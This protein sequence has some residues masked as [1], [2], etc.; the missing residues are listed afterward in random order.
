MWPKSLKSCFW[1]FEGF[2]DWS[3]WS[4]QESEKLVFGCLFG[5]GFL[6]FLGGFWEA[7]Q[8]EGPKSWCVVVVLVLDFGVCLGF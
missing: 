7:G 3:D 6:G 5:F 2:W 1:G 8:P 4:A